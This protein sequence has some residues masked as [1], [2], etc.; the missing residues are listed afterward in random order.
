M[1][2]AESRAVDTPAPVHTHSAHSNPACWSTVSPP[3]LV[4][5]Q[6]GA[7]AA[8]GGGIEVLGEADEFLDH[9]H[10]ADGAVVVLPK[11]LA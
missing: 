10:R 11:H 7:F 1:E 2:A 6:A 8:L 4:V 3:F 9:L 5:G